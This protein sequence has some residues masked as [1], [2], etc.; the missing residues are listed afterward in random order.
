MSKKIFENNVSC[1]S[2]RCIFGKPKNISKEVPLVYDHW[3]AYWYSILFRS[4]PSLT[5]LVYHNYRF[6]T[7]LAIDLNNNSSLSLLIFECFHF[8]LSSWVLSIITETYVSW[9]LAFVLQFKYSHILRRTLSNPGKQMLS[10]KQLLTSIMSD[11][12]RLLSPL[13]YQEWTVDL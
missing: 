8:F 13:P 6:S 5:L 11:V 10:N 9:L 1:H 3:F 4:L 7:C 12:G 2:S